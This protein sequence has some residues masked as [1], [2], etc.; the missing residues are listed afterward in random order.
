MGTAPAQFD[1]IPALA[2]GVGYGIEVGRPA[3][4]LLLSA[5][6]DYE[7]LRTQGHA[8][9]SIRHGQVIMRRTPSELVWPQASA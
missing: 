9:L 7:L 5:D 8:L 4:L 1:F 2:L 6:S 3:N